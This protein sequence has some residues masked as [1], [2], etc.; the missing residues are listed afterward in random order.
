MSWQWAES[1]NRGQHTVVPDNVACTYVPHGNTHGSDG[2][3]VFAY[4]L[5]IGADRLPGPLRRSMSI[6]NGYSTTYTGDPN[7]YAS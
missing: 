2:L 1:P 5:L 7:N 6:S 3:T 4:F